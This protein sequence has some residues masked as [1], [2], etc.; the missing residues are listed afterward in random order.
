M[1]H[2][3]LVVVKYEGNDCTGHPGMM[4]AYIH[5]SNETS[6]NNDQNFVHGSLDILGY[7]A[8]D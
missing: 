3:Q 4:V 8:T 6:G 2:V 1:Q 5:F 7:E